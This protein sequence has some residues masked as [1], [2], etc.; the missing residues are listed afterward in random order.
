MSDLVQINPSR[1][2]PLL[3]ALV[4]LGFAS[5]GIAILIFGNVNDRLAGVVTALFFG[6]ASLPWL[7]MLIRPGPALLLDDKGLSVRSWMGPLPFL[8]WDQIA[9]IG[10]FSLKGNVMVILMLKDP[11]GYLAQL[12][13]VSRFIAKSNLRYCGCPAW[14][15]ANQMQISH[16]D[17]YDLVDRYHRTYHRAHSQ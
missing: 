9:G 5:I 6:L 1:L 4:A 17:L 8:T 11:D 12:G 7:L 13:P 3:I 14:L 2:K 10:E 15:S 16:R